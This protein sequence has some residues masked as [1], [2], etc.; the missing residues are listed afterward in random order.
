M[1]QVHKAGEKVFID[2]SGV[3][4]ATADPLTG[5]VKYAEIFVAVLGA[6]GYPFV[7]AVPSQKKADFIHAHNEILKKMTHP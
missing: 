4:V 2:F 7:L 5:E 1:R 3:R 6:S